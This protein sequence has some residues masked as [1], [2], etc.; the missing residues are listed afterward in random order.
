MKIVTASQMAELDRQTTTIAGI[1]EKTL[2]ARAGKTASEWITARFLP[3]TYR[4]LV[5]IGKGHN[6]ADGAVAAR[7]LRRLGYSI[8]VINAWEKKAIQIV[9]AE[10]EQQRVQDKKATPPCQGGKW[11]G[12]LPMVTFLSCTHSN[13]VQNFNFS[14]LTRFLERGSIALWQNHFVRW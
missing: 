10:I 12:L 6:G 14:L 13:E 8:K 2:I 9:E 4:V 3:A 7:W 5:I 1:S 11:G